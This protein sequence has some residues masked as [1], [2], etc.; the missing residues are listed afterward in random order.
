MI[1]EFC[2]DVQ[3]LAISHNKITMQKANRL[4]G[5]SMPEPGVS[6]IVSVD[7]ESIPH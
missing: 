3:F 1:A 6:K 2:E 5:V 7:M 4:I